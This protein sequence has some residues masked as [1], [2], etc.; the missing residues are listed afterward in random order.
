LFGS[1]CGKRT[2]RCASSADFFYNP[3][4]FSEANDIEAILKSVG[5]EPQADHVNKVIEALK[6]K[7]LHEV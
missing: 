7:H 6:G 4:F 2:P 1:P 3:F 5:I